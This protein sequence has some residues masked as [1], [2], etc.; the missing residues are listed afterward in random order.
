[1]QKTF[2]LL[3]L[4]TLILIVPQNRIEELLNSMEDLILNVDCLEN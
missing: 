4:Y 2:L 3:I 1:M